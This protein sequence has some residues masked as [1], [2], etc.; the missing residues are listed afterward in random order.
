[1]QVNAS[2]VHDFKL[3]LNL[4]KE[5]FQLIAI[6]LTAQSLN[7]EKVVNTKFDII[8]VKVGLNRNCLPTNNI[9][10]YKADKNLTQYSYWFLCVKPQNQSYEQSE[11]SLSL[12][13]FTTQ[14]EEPLELSRLTIDLIKPHT[15]KNNFICGKPEVPIGLKSNTILDLSKYS[16]ECAQGFEN[17]N[18]DTSTHELVCGSDMKW[19]GIL[20]RCFPKNTCSKFKTNVRGSAEVRSYENV[21]FNS[22]DWFPIKGTV[23]RFGCNGKANANIDEGSRICDQSGHWDAER[24]YCST[25]QKSLV[26]VV[27]FYLKI[28]SNA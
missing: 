9:S 22:T 28:I 2:K 10:N 19:L 17:L 21:Y 27:I 26:Y 23:V 14:S 20:P 1:V 4:P 18:S 24:P 3:E 11:S 5:M 12:L 25:N 6:G 13:K 15:T 7:H 16:F 8:N